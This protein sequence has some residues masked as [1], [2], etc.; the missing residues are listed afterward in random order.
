MNEAP[1]A[2]GRTRGTEEGRERPPKAGQY[3][4]RSSTLVQLE[5]NTPPQECYGALAGRYWMGTPGESDLASG[6]IL[7]WE[8]IL[9]EDALA[10]E[11]ELKLAFRERI[12]RSL[13]A[14]FGLLVDPEH[15]DL[16]RV[17]WLLIWE[18]DDDLL[19]RVRAF[20]AGWSRVL[21]DGTRARDLKVADLERLGRIL[22]AGRPR[23]RRGDATKP[24]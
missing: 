23:T 6:S 22:G 16:D 14:R 12:A 15:P 1:E 2:V 18:A 20:E 21:P 9:L 7:F 17:E 4:S 10:F 19:D 24:A 13:A 5:P 11:S 8:P 3:V